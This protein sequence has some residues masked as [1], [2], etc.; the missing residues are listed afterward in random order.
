MAMEMLPNQGLGSVLE[1]S[2]LFKV[3]VVAKQQHV[4]RILVFAIFIQ[5]EV[6]VDSAR[7]VSAYLCY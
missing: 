7:E 1:G 6:S 3:P 2:R 5:V 4:N